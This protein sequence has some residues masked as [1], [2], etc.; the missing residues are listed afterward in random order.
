MGFLT[1]GKTLFEVVENVANI[2]LA[3]VEIVAN[4][5]KDVTDV[6]AEELEEMVEDLKE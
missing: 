6:V 3:P 5:T 4:V 1:L 2:A